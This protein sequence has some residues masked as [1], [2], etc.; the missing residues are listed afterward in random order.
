MSDTTGTD[1][2][3]IDEATRN[4]NADVTQAIRD[5]KNPGHSAFYSS[6]KGND[7]QTKLK[8]AAA[9]ANSIPLSDHLNTTIE[10]VDVVVSPVDIEDEKTGVVSTVPR[11]VLIDSNGIAYHAT[12]L[13][14]FSSIETLIGIIGEPSTWDGPINT[15]AVEQKTRKGY[16]VITLTY[17]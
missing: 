9:L 17:V 13:G 14:V 4:A 5:L 11:I 2:D 8:V 3:V 6:I 7:F 1:I 16:K 10:L 12:S 15:V